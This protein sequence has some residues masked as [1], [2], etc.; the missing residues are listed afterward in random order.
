MHVSQHD[1]HCA[2]GSIAVHLLS[3]S[4]RPQLQQLVASVKAT[5]DSQHF[6]SLHLL[7]GICHGCQAVPPRVETPDVVLFGRVGRPSSLV[8]KAY[9]WEEADLLVAFHGISLLSCSTLGRFLSEVP[10]FLSR[11]T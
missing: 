11:F 6:V 3:M 2:L 1:R 10:C 5:S 8:N 9:A 4:P 7:T